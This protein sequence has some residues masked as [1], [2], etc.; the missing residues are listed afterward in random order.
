VTLSLF[1]L[2]ETAL[3]FRFFRFPA[4]FAPFFSLSFALA[5]PLGFS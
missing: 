1:A 2:S 3:I 5:D 4:D